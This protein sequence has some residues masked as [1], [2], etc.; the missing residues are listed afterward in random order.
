MASH[1][2]G[3]QSEEQNEDLEDL[4]RQSEAAIESVTELIQELAGVDWEYRDVSPG[5]DQL[6]QYKTENVEEHRESGIFE[7][8]EVGDK[9]Q[10]EVKSELSKEEIESEFHD[11]LSSLILELNHIKTDVTENIP[12]QEKNLQQELDEMER[13]DA[14]EKITRSTEYSASDAATQTELKKKSLKCTIL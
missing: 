7:L 5:P 12:A 14:E 4:I 6:S 11:L 10:L 2:D 1:N 8:T 13:S 3:S 9:N